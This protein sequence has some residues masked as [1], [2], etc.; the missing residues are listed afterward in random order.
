MDSRT[1]R[2][3][4]AA[5]LLL[6][7]RVLWIEMPGGDGRREERRGDKDQASAIVQVDS[8]FR[9]QPGDRLQTHRDFVEIGDPAR[10]G[11]GVLHE[12]S[13]KSLIHCIQE[14]CLSFCLF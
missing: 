1:M 4:F 6:G 10:A 9:P 5:G 13:G 2:R 7:L 12:L 3:N 14:N 8:Q 11:A